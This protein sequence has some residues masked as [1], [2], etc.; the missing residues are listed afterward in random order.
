MQDSLCLD[1]YAGALFE[2]LWNVSFQRCNEQKNQVWAKMQPTA[3][4]FVTNYHLW[5]VPTHCLA[6]QGQE[7]KAVP[8]VAGGCPK[9][10]L[11]FATSALVHGDACL[12]VSDFPELLDANETARNL[13]KKDAT[14]QDCDGSESQKFFY[15]Y[16][17][18]IKKRGQDLC[19]EWDVTGIFLKDNVYFYTCIQHRRENQRWER[20]EDS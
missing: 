8:Y 20:V 13:A 14:L 19:L 11:D 2:H 16:D 10:Q 6:F 12:T 17:G 1:W 5:R 7:V 18:F 4:V 9:W 15:D 3:A